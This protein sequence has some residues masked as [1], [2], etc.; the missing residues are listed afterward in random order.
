MLTTKEIEEQIRV[1]VSSLSGEQKSTYLSG[2][3]DGADVSALIA[4]DNKWKLA[5][6]PH[7]QSFL[8]FLDS[9]PN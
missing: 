6:S 3:R 9:N 4:D 2:L 7:F 1:K 5:A 8:D